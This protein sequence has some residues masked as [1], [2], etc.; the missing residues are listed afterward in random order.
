MIIASIVIDVHSNKQKEL[1]QT[2]LALAGRVRKE[3]GCVSSRIS[4][5]MENE[6][7][8]WIFEQW[9]SRTDLDTHLRSDNFRV[10]RGALKLLNGPGKM[11]FHSVSQT[12]GEEVVA[13][14][15]KHRTN[16]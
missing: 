12:H 13:A 9:Q 14:A 1:T 3:V 5:D 4:R 11:R 16:G 8:L 7:V 15:R 10:L 2:L 6:N